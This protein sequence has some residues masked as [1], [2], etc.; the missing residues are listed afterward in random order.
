MKKLLNLFILILFVGIFTLSGCGP[1]T[2]PKQI[3]DKDNAVGEFTLFTHE[4]NK[5]TL[6]L[7]FNLGHSYLSFTNTSNETISI[8]TY[9]CSPGETVCIGTWS[10][11]SHFGVWYNVESNYNICNNRYDGRLSI[12]KQIDINDVNTITKFIEEN[13]TWS[14]L[15]NCS[16]FALNCWNEIAS[17]SEKISK[18]VIYTPSHIA[19]QI[20]LF[21][22]YET[23]KPM[24]TKDNFGYFEDDTYVAFTM[25]GDANYV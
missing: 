5:N 23:N 6:P 16:N 17:E 7:I 1:D 18:P 21:S 20:R 3:V 14:P 13:N 8:S 4:G 19:S 12:S 2:T 25:K 22:G 9:A 15:K 11:S 10:I 24:V